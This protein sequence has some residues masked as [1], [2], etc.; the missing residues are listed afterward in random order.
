MLY[1]VSARL[2]RRKSQKSHPSSQTIL[3]VTSR[4]RLAL[5]QLLVTIPTP[6]LIAQIPNEI[7]LLPVPITSHRPI[8]QHLHPVKKQTSSIQTKIRTRTFSE[9]VANTPIKSDLFWNKISKL[10]VLRINCQ[11]TAF[12]NQISF[13]TRTMSFSKR[14]SVVLEN[15][16]CTF[17][18][19][20]RPESVTVE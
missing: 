9:K 10:I 1:R 7:S 12:R 6:L 3:H 15:Q 5:L 8:W 4:N 18:V 13:V 19:K 2:P 11:G 16:G 20:Y 17:S 14:S